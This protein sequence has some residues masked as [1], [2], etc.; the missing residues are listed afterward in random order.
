MLICLNNT[1]RRCLQEVE[2]VKASNDKAAE[3]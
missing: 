1:K 3:I 2:E